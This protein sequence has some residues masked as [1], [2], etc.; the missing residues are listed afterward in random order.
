MAPDLDP[1]AVSS[2][3][4]ALD[5]P[6]AAARLSQLVPELNEHARLY[7]ERDAA[8]IDDRAY[9][10]LYR[11]LELIEARF[12]DLVRE[13][14]PTRR[15]GGAPVDTLE[16]F[17]HRVPML[18]LANSF[19]DQELREFETR[20]GRILGDAAPE[21]IAYVVEPK[22]DGLA[23]ELV[24]EDGRLTGAGT[25]GDGQVGEDVLHNI[26]TIRSIPATLRGAE[27]PSY[28]SV[29]GE[30]LYTL[31]GF[32]QMNRKRV[33]E[34]AK[35]FENP[36]NAAAGTIRQLDPRIAA[37]RP[38]T[39]VAHSYGLI[40]GL[41]E[42]DTHHEQLEQLKGWGIPVNPLN[43]R[44]EGIDAVI[45]AIGALGA[46]REDL[47]YEIDGAVVK[48]DDRGLQQIL[49]FVTRSPRWAIA[50]KY[51]PPQVSTVLEAVTF[52]VG[53]TGAITPVANLRPVRVGGVTVSRA[54][55][56]NEDQVRELDVRE[57]DT[58]VIERAGDVIPR[59]VRAVP[60]DAHAARPAVAFP[61]TCPAC[62][63]EVHRDPEMAVIRC[64]N[65]LSCPA[66]LRAGLRHFASRGAMD[67]DGL[68][69]KLID[70][71]VDRGLV[72][73]VSDLYRLSRS[74]ITSLE[75]MGGKSADNLIAALEASKE[76]PLGR[77]VVALGI[78]T[79]GEATAR[80]LANHFGS[81]D[82]LLAATPAQLCEVHGIGGVVAAEVHRFFADE[83]HRAEI[84]ALRELGVQFPEVAATDAAPTSTALAGLTFVITGTLP[85]MERA[86]AERRIVE[87]GGKCTGSVSKKTSYVVAG[88]KAGSK[89]TK[90][91]AL[92]VP[93]IDE[94]E[95][96][97][98]LG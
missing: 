74:Q 89:L 62:G 15:V 86:E 20:I 90:A 30:V 21:R 28:V 2:R 51:P 87:A 31:A 24:Y 60:D 35:A 25:R 65:Q 34:G 59:V 81:I 84:A 22:L 68:G 39:F 96:V 95:L 88:E 82:A 91:Q 48:V 75:R 71:L 37:E 49:G 42:P 85:T 8:V 79:V 45:A 56:H 83:R 10:L 12:P 7:Y 53:R 16:P 14:S 67:V 94:G 78:P 63:T 1:A 58:V 61:T 47:G 23:I 80:D 5:A 36:R 76:R 18:S 41:E 97:R 19:A 4:A 3:V 46:Q 13:D 98:L 32:E 77:C 50:F 38:L 93:V 54:T 72:K 26:R 44:V 9:D 33:A 27:L 69:Q 6:T 73:R 43:R 29:R 57:G 66:Q 55:L 70:Q 11:E 52:Q 92:G 17:P 40:E 64:P